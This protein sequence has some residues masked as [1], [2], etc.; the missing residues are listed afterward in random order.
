MSQYEP[1]PPHTRKPTRRNVR[2]GIVDRWYSHLTLKDAAGNPILDSNGREQRAPTTR[3]GKGMRWQARFVT[4]DGREVG[5]SFAKRA[6]AQRWLDS[7]T[8]DVTR[9]E[10]IHGERQAMTVGEVAATWKAHIEQLKPSTRAGYLNRWTTHVEPRW[11]NVRL[12]DVEHAAIV[13][14][15]A[16][17]RQAGQSPSSIA[18][19]WGVLNQVLK[20]ATRDGRL[21]RNPATDVRLPKTTHAE[22]NDLRII[23]L[24]DLRTLARKAEGAEV[25]Q[26]GTMILTLG[27]VGLRFG[28]LAG[29][30]IGDIEFTKRTM[31]ISRN[32]TEVD[33]HLH[34]GS[35][36]SGKPRTVT[37][38]KSL[39]ER[40]HVQA[41][42][43]PT[44]AYLFPQGGLDASGTSQPIRRTNWAKRVFTPAVDKAGLRPLT[45]HD[46]RHCYAAST[47]S[48]G[49]SVYVVQ[50]QL[51]HA[52]PSIT[53]DIYGYLFEE[54]LNSA[55]DRLDAAIEALDRAEETGQA[56]SDDVDASADVSETA[57]A[58]V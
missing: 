45:V 31:R 39:T 50:R 12:A 23:T 46:L 37:F 9:G 26:N 5:K 51:G 30:R 21:L 54:D 43:R 48:A 2:S 4:R 52:R 15:V 38:P 16:E 57:Q 18:A 17:L 10:F 34:I 8:A 6:D 29:L 28:E 40:L 19:C 53:L 55:A 33:G 49:A 27:L 42:G 47:L 35:P 3:H 24:A 56:D 7:Q 22:H 14:W 13:Q 20:V 44:D 11:G 25:G 36:K 1:T 58:T 32:V 41:A